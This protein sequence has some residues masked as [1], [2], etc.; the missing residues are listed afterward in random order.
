MFLC[1]CYG[2]LCVVVVLLFVCVFVV[3]VMLFVV[4]VFAVCCVWFV[5]LVGMWWLLVW[6]ALFFVCCFYR[7][8]C[9]DY[10]SIGSEMA[11]KRDTL[12][13]ANGRK[14]ILECE[15]RIQVHSNHLAAHA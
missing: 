2:W 9:C 5:V 12:Y 7:A 11:I 15:P 1:V 3:C 10:H 4:S 8:S 13:S 14:P 6:C